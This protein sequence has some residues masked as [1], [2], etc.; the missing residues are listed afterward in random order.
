MSLSAENP[1]AQPSSLPYGMPD[2]SAIRIEHIAPAITEGFAEQRA[3]W[4]KIATDT[5]PATV[6]SVLEPLEASGQLLERA[7]GVLFSQASSIGGDAYDALEEEF[8][9]QLS[10]HQDAFYLDKRIYQRLQEL[11]DSDAEL[12]LETSWLLDTYLKRFR[13]H[14]VELEAADQDRLRE[15]NSQIAKLQTAFGQKVVKAIQ[16]HAPTFTDAAE[17][18]G[19]SEAELAALKQDDGSYKVSLVS[20]TQQPIAASLDNPET[21]ARIFEASATRNWGGDAETDTRQVVLD[22]ARARAERAQLLG[23]AHHADYYAEDA[24]AGTSDAIMERLTAMAAPAARNAKAEAAELAEL[25]A[26]DTDRAF[27]PSDWSYYSEKLR[28]EKFNLDDAALKPY[29]LLENVIDKGVFFAANKLYGLTFTPRED[30][31]GHTPDAKVWEVFDRDGSGIGMFSADYYA[32]DGKRGGAWM[33]GFVSQ[34][35]L[36]DHCAVVTN[37]LNV[38]KPKDGPTL[39]TWDEV[40]TCFHEFGHALHG[41]LSKVHWP[42]QSGTSVP[43]DFVE[44]PSQ[45][46]EMWMVNPHVIANFARH[47]ETGEQIPAEYIETLTSMGAY[48][49]GF[50]TSEYLGAALLDQAWHRLSPDEVPTSVE[51]VAAFEERVLSEFGIDVVPPRYRTAFFNHTFGGGYDAGYYSYVWAEV[52][53][54]D[55]DEWFRTEADKDGDGGLNAEAG[56][57]LRREVLSR[58]YSRDPRESFL[59]F[60]GRDPEVGPL[61]TRRGLA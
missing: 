40:R 49:E 59:A 53:D 24:A 26:R 25:M 22:L 43:A 1:L 9:P 50:G 33:S 52:L 47:Y 56:E 10:S 16:S 20:T 17:L 57:Q 12:D 31:T 39:L 45:L 60:R 41:L 7:L 54:A 2:F 8:F 14:G 5:S 19:L 51:D 48:G 27:A 29:L 44:Y 13:R 34:S 58:G 15:L 4:E 61:M 6:E 36:L 42:S 30:I 18:A 3:E 38:K 21:R 35:E 32:R 28:A 55:T 46:N 11:A 23:Y 37:D